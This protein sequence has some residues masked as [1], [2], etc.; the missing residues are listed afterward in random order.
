MLFA[1]GHNIYSY[2][3]C[4]NTAQKMKLSIK[5]FFSKCGFGHIYWKN[6]QWKTSFFVQ[7]KKVEYNENLYYRTTN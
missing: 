1:N 5:N 7:C 4:N 3:K 2:H 6:P